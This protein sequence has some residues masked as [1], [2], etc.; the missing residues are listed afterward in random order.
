MAFCLTIY[1]EAGTGGFTIQRVPPDVPKL[2]RLAVERKLL[3]PRKGLEHSSSI[4][5]AWKTS[6]VRRSGAHTRRAGPR[7]P[8]AALSG[9]LPAVEEE[10]NEWRRVIDPLFPP[11]SQVLDFNKMSQ[12]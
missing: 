6:S 11:D 7:H 4:L 1:D 12:Y 8:P 3:N 9:V 10:Y 5:R 2:M